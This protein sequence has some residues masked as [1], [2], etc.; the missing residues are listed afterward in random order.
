MTLASGYS[1]L[2]AESRTPVA[3]I[4][5]SVKQPMTGASTA[6]LRRIFLG[7]TTRWPTHRR[8][9]LLVRPAEVEEQ[10]LLLRR[11][12]RMSDIDYSQHWLGQVFRGEAASPPRTVESVAAMKK[13][14]VEEPD[15]IGLLDLNDLE[16]ADLH[17]LR[18]L[19]VDGKTPVDR[20]YVLRK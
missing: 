5:V 17:T 18:M 15:A 14:V 11:V 19:A 13:A 8:V 1:C 16:P 2:A 9:I 12:V 6:E 10:K 20:D 4:I 7:L 3:V